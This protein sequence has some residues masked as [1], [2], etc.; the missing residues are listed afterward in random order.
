LLTSF[1]VFTDKTM[2]AYLIQKLGKSKSLDALK[3]KLRI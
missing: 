1:G 3:L 2:E